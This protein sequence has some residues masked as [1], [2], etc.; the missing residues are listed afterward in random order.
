MHSKSGSCYFHPK[1][2]DSFR[3]FQLI[4]FFDLVLK[5]AQMVHP[6]KSYKYH[7]KIGSILFFWIRGKCNILNRLLSTVCFFEKIMVL[8]LLIFTLDTYRFC[9]KCIEFTA[10]TYSFKKLAV[11][12][13]IWSS[14][15][16]VNSSYFHQK[17]V[18]AMFFVAY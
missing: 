16:G 17:L 18:R 1:K 2:R 7:L 6:V 12:S 15:T 4:Y 13:M 5:W 10:R 8:S 11:G 14:K 3:R 9:M